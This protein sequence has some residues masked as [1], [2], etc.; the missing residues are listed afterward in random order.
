MQLIL[1]MEEKMKNEYL[2]TLI[3]KIAEE[4]GYDVEGSDKQFY[5]QIDRW[6]AVAYKIQENRVGYLQ[7]HQWEEDSEDENGYYGRA[8]YSLRNI[9]DVVQFCNILLASASIRAKRK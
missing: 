2:V 6:N 4:Q 3:K 7:V 9:T 1:K 8:V 5:V